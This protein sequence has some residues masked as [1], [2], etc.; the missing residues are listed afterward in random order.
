MPPAPGLPAALGLQPGEAVP[1]SASLSV[2]LDGDRVVY[3]HFTDPVDSHADDDKPGRNRCLGR[4]ALHGLAS[5]AQLVRAL[6]VSPQ[7]VGR[8]RQ[9]LKR[10]RVDPPGVCHPICSHTVRA[11]SVR[12]SWGKNCT[13]ES[14]INSWDRAF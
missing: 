1:I 12:L 14:R 5:Q 6:G 3:F 4:F 10:R 13:V 2:V 11:S 9:R 7:T 8:A